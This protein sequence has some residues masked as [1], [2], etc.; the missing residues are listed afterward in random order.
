MAISIERPVV[1]IVSSPSGKK[2]SYEVAGSTWTRTYQRLA[3]FDTEAEAKKA[4]KAFLKTF[5][6]DATSIE[7]GASRPFQIMPGLVQNQ[8]FKSKAVVDLNRYSNV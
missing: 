3:T 4:G 8:L 7:T 5:D 1:N 2:F 6:E